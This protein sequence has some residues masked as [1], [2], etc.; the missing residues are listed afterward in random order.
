MKLS[1]FNTEQIYYHGTNCDFE[2]FES[3]ES[4]REGFLG[5]IEKV[6]SSVFFFTT[7]KQT[8]KVFAE[9]RAEY[10]GGQTYIKE[11]YLQYEKTLDL[12]GNMKIER[13]QNINGKSVDTHTGLDI[14][15]KL[16]SEDRLESSNDRCVY[17]TLC[18]VLGL[19]LE[20]EDLVEIDIGYCSENPKIKI[21]KYNYNKEGLLLLLD[22]NEIVNRI[23]KAGYDSVL[24]HEG[25]FEGLEL[26]KSIAVL[27]PNQ[28]V[29][30]SV[31]D[32]EL[33]KDSFKKESKNKKSKMVI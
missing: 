11:C 4:V 32:K 16:V 26:G 1:I 9:N 13:Y 27:S 19:D 20:T 33:V 6:K 5:S 21:N 2:N 29:K 24:C 7:S 12:T 17:N 23:K 18:D 22:D 10:L 25:K 30:K 8:A 15:T 14:S 3:R 28:V 31:L